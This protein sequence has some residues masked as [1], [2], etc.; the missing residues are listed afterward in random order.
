[1]GIEDYSTTA[2]SNNSASPNGFPEGMAPSGV[3]DSARQVMADIRTWYEDAE[4]IDWGDTTTYSSGTAFT[5]STGSDLT[6][7][8]SAGRRVRAVGSSTGTIY[9]VI[10]SSSYSSPVTTVNVSWDSGSLQSETLTISGGI[11]STTNKSVHVDALAGGVFGQ[12]VGK[13]SGGG[14]VYDF[15]DTSIVDGYDY[16]FIGRLLVPATDGAS[17]WVRTSN[18]GGSTFDEGASDYETAGLY[19]K[20]GSTVAAFGGTQ[21]RFTIGS[22]G[23]E[24]TSAQGGISF[25]M[26]LVDPGDSA[27]HTGMHATVHYEEDDTTFGFTAA[28]GKRTAAEAVDGVRFL[29]SSGNISSGTIELWQ[30]AHQ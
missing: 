10:S 17:L 15:D 19:T 2:A 16:I 3:N 6:D 28:A 18:D 11:I 29:F 24:N 5:L 21:T 9:G 13:V 14:S 4:W 26:T 7:R 1:M 23:V 27:T 12:Y 22:R 25:I 20:S 8:W 30:R